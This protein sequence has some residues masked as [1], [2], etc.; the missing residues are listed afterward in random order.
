MV[1]SRNGQ[2]DPLELAWNRHALMRMLAEGKMPQ[3]EMARRMG[4]APSSVT[5]FKQRHAEAIEAIAADVENEFAGIAIAQKS[6]RLA[7]YEEELA[8]AQAGGADKHIVARLLRQIAEE[9]GHLPSRVQ[10]SGTVGVQTTYT[11]TG[12]DGQPVDTKDLT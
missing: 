4:V 7:V 8:K 9:M 1:R 2:R 12:S 3:A 5:A 11:V 6:N 10:L